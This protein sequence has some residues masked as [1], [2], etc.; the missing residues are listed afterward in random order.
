M[1]SYNVIHLNVVQPNLP[2]T[3][4]NPLVFPGPR[5][6]WFSVFPMMACLRTPAAKQ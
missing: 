1:K 5:K 6:Q 4:L 3:L 2:V